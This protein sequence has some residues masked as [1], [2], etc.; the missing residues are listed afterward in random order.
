VAGDF[1]V[2]IITDLEG[3]ASTVSPLVWDSGE[4]GGTFAEASRILAGEVN[5]AVGAAFDAGATEVAVV[6]GHRNSLRGRLEEID[7]RVKLAFGVPFYELASR[8]FDCLMLVGYHAMA[9]AERAVLGHS[10]ADKGYVAS[11]LNGTLVG[12]IGH[13]AALFG[14]HGTPLAFVSG[15]G[16]ACRE[17]EELVEGTVTAVVKEGAHRFGAV[18]LTPSAA[19][20]LIAQKAGEAIEAVDEIVPLAFEPPIEFV[21][22]FSTT[23]P[24]ER[25]ILVP[26]IET[27]GPRR[28]VIRGETVSQVMKLFEL[29]G[30]IV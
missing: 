1:S 17:A 7:P 9:D 3:T 5:A 10:F 25:N 22:E 27:A 29:T 11:W 16:A 30:R 19:R 28:M 4:T 23:D 14:E 2:T 24:V 6:E 12:E 13:L 8:G 21:V 20:E 18:S 15:D 26:G